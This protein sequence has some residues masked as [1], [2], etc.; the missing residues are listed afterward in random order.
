M[1]KYPGNPCQTGSRRA[2]FAGY[3]EFY[4]QIIAWMKHQIL[5][6]KASLI[7]GLL[8]SV[9]M[10]PAYAAAQKV[11]VTGKVANA[12]GE[13]IIGATIVVQNNTRIGT[14]SDVQGVFRLDVAPDAVL[15]VSYIGY[16][17]QTIPVSGKTHLNV[18]LQEDVQTLEDVVVVGY[19][20]QKKETVVG[21]ISSVAGNRLVK[22]P[23]GNVSNAL[24]GRVSG[25]TAVQKSGEPGVDEATIRVRGVG[26]FAGDQNPLVVIDGVVM[27]ISDMNSMDPNDIE[28]V[29]VLKDASATAVYGVRGANGVIIVTTRKGRTGAPQITFSANIGFNRASSLPELANAYEYALMRNEAMTN[30]GTVDATLW[31]D[32]DQLWKFKNNRDYT[33]KEVAAM[34]HLTEEQR[35]ALRQSPA[36]YY[37]SRDYLKM[38]FDRTALQQQYNVNMSG[39]TEKVNYFVSLGYLSQEG[40]LNNFGFDDSPADSRNQRINFRTNFDFNFIKNL[41]LNLAV[42]G[43]FSDLRSFSDSDGSLN[44][45]G[46][47]RGVMVNIY[48]TTPFAGPGIVDGKLVGDYA[49]EIPKHQYKG[50]SP[51]GV[52]L[53]RNIA[54][55]DSNNLN[56][57]LR[58]KYNLGFITEG[59]SVRGVI[60]YNSYFKKTVVE[61]SDIPSYSFTRNPGNPNEYIFLKG[62]KPTKSTWDSGYDK[63]YK[64]Y[65][66]GGIDY[67]RKFGRH[68]VSALALVT[69]EK[70]TLP[71]LLYNVPQGMYGVVGRVTYSFDNRYLGEFN[72]GYNGSENF[73]PGKRFGVFPAVSVGWIISNEKFFPKNDILTMLKLRGSYGQTGNSNVGGRRFMF[74]PGMWED[75]GSYGKSF[76]GYPF[77]YTDGTY[78]PTNYVGKAEKTVGNPDVTWEKKESYNI[79]LEANFFRDRLLF[80]IDLFKE[81]RNN[82]LTTLATV[83]GIIGLDSSVLPPMNVGA[84]NNQGYEVSLK[85]RDNARDFSYEIGGQVSY[86]KNKIVEMAEAPYPYSWMNKTGYSYGQYKAYLNEGF[87]NSP[88]EAANHPYNVSAGNKA[89]AGDLRV[90]DINGDGIIN[91]QDKIPYGYS[92]VP[93][94][95]FSLNLFLGYKGVEL[96]AL[97]TGSAQGNFVMEG[98]MVNPFTAKGQVMKYMYEGRWTPERYAAGGEITYPRMSMAT[99]NSTQNGVGNSFWIRSTNHIKLKNLEVAYAIRDKRWLKKLRISTL[100]VYVNTNNLFTIKK[101]DLPKG[102]DP[103]LVQDQYTS[104]GI[105]YPIARTYNFGVR[106]QF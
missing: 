76:Q 15:N 42:S 68:E 24:L 1:K 44:T 46:R 59:L 36:I 6:L 86:S 71:G 54:N 106:L 17:T 32:D 31:F 10:S 83:P 58:G 97:F 65:V 73:A 18:V 11:S 51:I 21:A 38:M 33:L 4:H 48:E 70:K 88:Q 20:V 85:W 100:R 7:I 72:V 63:N 82:I 25:L 12:K 96:S 80:T 45:G 91:E 3:F 78:Y 67:S 101:S 16:V 89:Q 103:E 49:G 62:T 93:R 26:T 39:G 64:L 90:V 47:Y 79:A 69:A 29:N 13:A 104:E 34:T 99:N 28:T 27:S 2:P 35:V 87:Y 52:L 84:M 94:F 95:G 19:G 81:K 57:S 30:D 105:I 77:G 102:V 56:A 61:S 14:T 75:F 66:E 40:L 43:T 92:N 37:A 60:S 9:I 55:V 53:S 5:Y 23:V 8:V 41:E 74:L 98:Y 22:S 50:Y